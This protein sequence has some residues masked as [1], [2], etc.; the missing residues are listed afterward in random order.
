[1]ITPIATARKLHKQL[2]KGGAIAHANDMLARAKSMSLDESV[3]FWSLVLNDLKSLRESFNV[4][5]AG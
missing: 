1:M 4:R 3:K 5:S 2:G